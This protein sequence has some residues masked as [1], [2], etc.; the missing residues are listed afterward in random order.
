MADI[1]TDAQYRAAIG[2]LN[3]N[4]SNFQVFSFGIGITIIVSL[5]LLA[6]GLIG[7]GTED[8]TIRPDILN[9]F[10]IVML[11]CCVLLALAYIAYLR[12]IGKYIYGRI[13]PFNFGSRPDECAPAP[14]GTT[15]VSSR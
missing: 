14:T 8:E 10:A 15:R 2:S 7:I 12:N 9:A 3:F 5:S 13:K 6:G 11:I 1:F 4:G